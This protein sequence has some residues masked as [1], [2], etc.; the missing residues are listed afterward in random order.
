MAKR[1][2]IAGALGLIGRAVL[3]HLER[4]GGWDLVGLSRRNADFPTSARF[5]SVD[6][7]DRSACQRDLVGLRDTTHI[8]FAALHEKPDLARGWRGS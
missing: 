1:M 8:V 3:Q 2:V 4:V 5:V 6:L 7:M